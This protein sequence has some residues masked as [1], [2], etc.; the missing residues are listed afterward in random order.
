MNK[1]KAN[2]FKENLELLKEH[3]FR[4][5]TQYEWSKYEYSGV[6]QLNADTL[7]L[8]PDSSVSLAN[9]KYFKPMWLVKENLE[10]LLLLN[11][12]SYSLKKVTKKKKA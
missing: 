1:V 5:T 2:H 3:R 7:L 11:S 10:E 4:L 8:K 6:W 12:Q 9:E